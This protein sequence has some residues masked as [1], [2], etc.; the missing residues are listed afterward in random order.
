[1]G[2]TILEVAFHAFDSIAFGPVAR[3]YI[4]D[5]RSAY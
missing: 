3:R 2:V 4:M 1:L 5:G